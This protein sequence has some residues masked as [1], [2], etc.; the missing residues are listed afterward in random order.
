MRVVVADVVCV[1]V[2]ETA[3]GPGTS[4]N[5]V[6]LGKGHQGQNP[7][8]GVVPPLG[9]SLTSSSWCVLCLSGGSLLGLG[10]G[11]Q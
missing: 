6:G 7:E 2:T 4:W 10:V 3:A 5:D 8:S 9:R 1:S 11:V